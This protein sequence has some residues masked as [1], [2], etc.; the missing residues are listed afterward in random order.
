MPP[1]VAGRLPIIV[2]PNLDGKVKGSFG[3]TNPI[4]GVDGSPVIHDMY[5]RG[6][7]Q[8]GL[9]WEPGKSWRT[10]LMVPYGRGGA[11][12]SVLDITNP[13]IKNKKGPLHMFS[14]YND[15]INNKVKIANHIG[16]IEN[17]PYE[18]GAITL[19]RSEEAIRAAAKSNEARDADNA[20]AGT[21]A[22]GNQINC[23][24]TDSCT[25]QDAVAVCHTNADA[26]S[27]SF[28]VDGETAC[29]KGTKF[30]FNN[31]PV[32]AGAD[33]TVS[34]DSLIVHEAQET[35]DS[36]LVK[37]KSAKLI[38]TTLEIEFNDEKFVNE[39]TSDKKKDE[40][41]TNDITCLLYTSDAADE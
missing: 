17:Y 36:V 24:E 15:A 14:V 13:I 31:L 1:F 4:F 37:I 22:D 16:E 8:D 2:N 34:T 29:Y 6:L 3:G 28:W 27:G 19:D 5:I 32:A 30:T 33:G 11:G 10:I 20:A 23:E 35:G 38:G 40:E 21:D 9:T 41:D 26:D 39:I 18:R 25:N 12:F 7:S